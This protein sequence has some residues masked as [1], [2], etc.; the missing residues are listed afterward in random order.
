MAHK[1]VTVENMTKEEHGKLDARANWALLISVLVLVGVLF[2][3]YN[4][5]KKD[6][7][8]DM[9]G[10]HHSRGGKNGNKP[11]PPESGESHVPKVRMGQ[12][13]D[14][15]ELDI[16]LSEGKFSEVEDRVGNLLKKDKSNFLANV[17]M[18]LVQYRKGEIDESLKYLERARNINPGDL[19]C[20][21]LLGK[22]HTFVDPEKAITFYNKNLSFQMDRKDLSVGAVRAYHMAAVKSDKDNKKKKEYM[23][24][25]SVLLKDCDSI[26]DNHV[27]VS[28]LD[29]LKGENALLQGQLKEAMSHYVKIPLTQQNMGDLSEKINASTALG[30]LCLPQG[31]KGQS[32]L[33][34][35][36]SLTMM[37]NWKELRAERAIPRNEEMLIIIH[38]LF[39]RP[40]LYFG[41]KKVKANNE[42]LKNAPIKPPGRSVELKEL[43]YK[44][45]EESHKDKNKE[46]LANAKKIL[47]ILEKKE[48]HFYDVG[49]IQPLF[50]RAMMIY[51]GDICNEMGNKKEAKRYYFMS[52]KGY[53]ALEKISRK[54][55]NSIK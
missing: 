34:F 42:F 4:K 13:I 24:T 50:Q 49:L 32:Y 15:R 47:E 2:L 29:L 27:P 18:G 36:K 28:Y 31:D 39:N 26:Q 1:A 8:R 10:R 33:Y 48:G 40:L 43:I 38:T 6:Y 5:Y 25:A 35:E 51:A 11:A 53:E 22:I 46:A 7:T 23:K 54:R 37:N 16:M 14:Q 3:L 45:A 52:S 41:L 44:M 30:I 12:G 9:P 20:L 19:Y 55:I 21:Q 17:Q